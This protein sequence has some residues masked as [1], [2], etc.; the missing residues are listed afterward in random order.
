SAGLSC[1]PG[2]CGLC[3]GRRGRLRGE[4]GCGCAHAG[5]GVRGD[6]RGR[7]GLAAAPALSNVR[8]LS[9]RRRVNSRREGIVV[10]KLGDL[11]EL[12]E[13]RRERC[14]RSIPPAF[15]FLFY[16]LEAPR[17]VETGADASQIFG[18]LSDM[19][20]LLQ[21]LFLLPVPVGLHQLAVSEDHQGLSRAALALGV[22]GSLTA[23]LAQAL[24]VAR[25]I[26]FEVNL[27]L[28][29]MGGGLI[30]VWMVLASH[31]GRL[32]GALAPRLAWLGEMTGA[33]FMVGNSLALLLVVAGSRDAVAV[34]NFGAFVQQHPV[35]IAAI[36]ILAV[37][38]L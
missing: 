5:S 2:G 28:F 26:T 24:L 6:D 35:V 17:L 16:G 19:A 31:L 12:S 9:A 29:L 30:G 1:W 8:S 32:R 15:L 10:G 13:I 11:G 4:P 25:V 21:F 3:R 37:P 38:G 22:V 27:P 33:I 23:V 36:I 7:A 18:P 20:G 34:S 14:Q